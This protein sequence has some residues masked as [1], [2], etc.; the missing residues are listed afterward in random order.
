VCVGV[1]VSHRKNIKDQEGGPDEKHVGTGV[2]IITPGTEA[3]EAVLRIW[4]RK[5]LPDTCHLSGRAGK[6]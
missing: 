6:D 1:Q 5:A 2:A 3:P 4:K